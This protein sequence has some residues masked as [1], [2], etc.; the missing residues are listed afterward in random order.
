VRVT[1]VKGVHL[2]GEGRR[3]GQHQGADSGTDQKAFHS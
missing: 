1:V 3:G 2:L